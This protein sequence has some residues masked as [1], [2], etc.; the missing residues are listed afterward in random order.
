MYC[1]SFMCRKN[2]IKM[3]LYCLQGTQTLCLGT[4]FRK[5]SDPYT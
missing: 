5:T 4:Q 1:D 2:H 3:S